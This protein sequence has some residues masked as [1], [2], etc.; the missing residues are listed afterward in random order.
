MKILVDI[1]ENNTFICP[2]C[3]EIV[4]LNA[5]SIEELILSNNNIK[6]TIN[7]T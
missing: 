5:E 6:E 1:I 4:K 3:G 7:G 2:K